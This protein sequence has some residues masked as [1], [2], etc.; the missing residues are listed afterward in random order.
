MLA[1]R[2]AIG[3]PELRAQDTKEQ[4][5]AEQQRVMMTAGAAPVGLGHDGEEE[6]V[7]E[8]LDVDDIVCKDPEAEAEERQHRRWV[9]QWAWPGGN[10]GG[11]G[12]RVQ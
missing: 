9:R 1:E 7:E 4:S 5:Q 6:E 11:L 8:T 12:G 3:V 2:T 10:G